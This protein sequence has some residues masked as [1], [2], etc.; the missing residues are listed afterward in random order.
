MTGCPNGC[1]R[2]YMAELGFVGDTPNS[3]EV[4]LGG[5]KALTRLAEPFAKQVKVNDIASFLE[6]ILYFFKARRQEG[7][8]FGDFVNRVGFE[9]L[10]TYQ[11]MYVPL[12]S[13]ARSPRVNIDNSTFS[14]LK[15]E[16][17]RRDRTLSDLASEAIQSYLTGSAE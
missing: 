11:G 8:H 14:L 13:G 2:P 6:P 17:E 7:E 15:S 16:A 1:A 5:N 12:P 9:M 10:R 4:W 3:Y